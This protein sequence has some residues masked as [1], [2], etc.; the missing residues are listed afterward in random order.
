MFYALCPKLSLA[1]VALIGC[2]EVTMML[3]ILASGSRERAEGTE[4]G[5]DMAE[6]VGFASL[7]ESDRGSGMRSHELRVGR[8]VP[9]VKGRNW[10]ETRTAIPLTSSPG[11]CTISASGQNKQEKYGELFL[12]KIREYL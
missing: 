3:A 9:G 8:L 2:I 7:S 10:P 5:L 1:I 6:L 11:S 12:G 4:A